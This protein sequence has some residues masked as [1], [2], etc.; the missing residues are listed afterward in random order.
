MKML[1]NCLS[2]S[3]RFTIDPRN[4]HHQTYCPDAPCQR[5]RRAL[6]QQG[7]RASR[8]VESRR[9]EV[10][11]TSRLQAGVKPTEADWHVKDP[12]F[13]GLILM[14]TGSTNVE[15]IQAVCRRLQERGRNI[16]GGRSGRDLPSIVE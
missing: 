6:A 8:S 4:D 1:R 3:R 13:I 5:Q 12:M 10:G 16:L 7:R 9:E 2:C 15:D 11:A 14:L